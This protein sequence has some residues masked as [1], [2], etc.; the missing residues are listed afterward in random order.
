MKIVTP[1]IFFSSF[2]TTLFFKFNVL[3][4]TSLKLFVK[5]VSN[6]RVKSYTI[7]FPSIAIVSSIL[8]RVAFWNMSEAFLVLLVQLLSRW[9]N[10]LKGMLLKMLI[11]VK[12]IVTS[13]LNNNAYSVMMQTFEGN[14]VAPL[15]T[16]VCYR[17][18][19]LQIIDQA[20]CLG[21][22]AW[23]MFLT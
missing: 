13:Y 6:F 14:L 9:S 19:Y 17:T 20:F 18:T 4:A 15:S 7:F 3:L 21:E 11:E 5:F 22:L 16:E 1:P 8:C 12:I 2:Q 10:T 23:S